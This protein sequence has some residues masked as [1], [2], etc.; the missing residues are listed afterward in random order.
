MSKS[1]SRAKR[2]DLVKKEKEPYFPTPFAPVLRHP[3]LLLEQRI[4]RFTK[5]IKEKPRWWEKVHDPAIVSRWTKEVV[6]H[7]QK[8][9]DQFWGGE[10]RNM[11]YLPQEGTPPMRRDHRIYEKRWPRDPFT[12]A[13]LR[14]LFDELKYDADQRDPETGTYRAAVPMVYEASALI[15]PALKSAVQDLA[16]SLEDVPDEQKDWHPGSNG[17]VLDLVHPSL[18]CLRIGNSFVLD[19]QPSH[20]ESLRQL[21]EDEY[22]QSR[23]DMQRFCA[24]DVWGKKDVGR[25]PFD[26]TVS[27]AYQWLPTDFDVYEDGKVTPKGYINNLNPL[28]HRAAYATV[29]SVLERFIPLFERVASDVL[30]PPPPSPFK[31]VNELK[32]YNH[33]D[34]THPLMDSDTLEG[35]EWR[36][37]QFWP[38][39][40]D[41][42][43][44]EPPPPEGRVT[45]SLRGRTLQVIVKLANIVL[46]PEN[47]T[48]SGGSWHVE[49]MMNEKI[50]ATGLYYYDSTNISASHLAFRAAIGDG[51]CWGAIGLP[52]KQN[53]NVGYVAAYGL[54]RGAALNQEFGDIVAAEDKCVAFP[55][56]YQH[57]VAP[58][59]LIDRTKP[60]HRKILAL[61]LVDP[62]ITILST[63]RVPPQQMEWYQE[64]VAGAERIQRL[65]QELIDLI[66]GF[67]VEYTITLEQAR[68]DRAELMKERAGFVF[69]HN[70]QYFEDSFQMCEH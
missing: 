66:L 32:W 68:A 49:G 14:Y 56:T 65:P 51:E 38:L 15:E 10:N 4:R 46:T 12:E 9:V 36:R 39:L 64:A 45:F 69:K 50:V 6:E 34:R 19:A 60:G 61:F 26:Y 8:M 20:G 29:S 53:D 47:P 48:Y 40:P 55:N 5:E 13:Q 21:S 52:G 35:K 28:T 37:S 41:A 58:F 16:R 63:T 44:F 70:E 11:A 54:P 62:T 43:P 33:V 42:E 27:R 30:S 17:K 31:G 24:E 59:G 23:K 2:R 25:T 22:I 7:D 3:T 57:R 67:V 18:Y 1:K